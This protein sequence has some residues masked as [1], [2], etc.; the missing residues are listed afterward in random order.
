[1]D[2][3]LPTENR[4]AYKAVSRRFGHR[5][6]LEAFDL[7]VRTHEL[8][9][10]LGASGAGKST[11][12]RIGAGLESVSAGTV[13]LD[14]LDVTLLPGRRRNVGFVFQTP[15]LF[16]HLSVEDN[17]ALP[18][19]AQRV[20]VNA[21]V[22][23]VDELI[24]SLH[25]EHLRKL[26]PRRLK[27]DERHLVA[28][29][30]ALVRDPL[31]FFMDEPL[32][33]LKGAPR[34]EARDRVRRIHS[35]LRTTTLYATDNAEDAFAIAD[36]IAILDAGKI[37]Q[38]GTPDQVKRNPANGVVQSFITASR[39]AATPAEVRNTVE[40]SMDPSRTARL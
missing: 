6:A 39:P 15:A 21:R 22:R 38:C 36:R 24:D 20:S 35:S 8:V 18:L 10:I 23:R 1:M 40:I 34:R 31:A 19:R 13:H 16:P 9:V 4:V 28:L 30:R 27:D 14:G 29:A 11:A 17:I 2:I 32:G 5:H 33:T 3:R 26:A 37:L 12:L 7:I 25:I